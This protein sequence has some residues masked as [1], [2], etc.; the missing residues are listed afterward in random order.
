MKFS[1]FGSIFACALFPDRVEAQ[2]GEKAAE[3]SNEFQFILKIDDKVR[4]LTSI[5]GTT[6]YT[7]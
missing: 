2:A 7:Y 6:R 1:K 4:T 3:V 5:E